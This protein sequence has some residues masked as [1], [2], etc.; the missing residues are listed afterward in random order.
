MGFHYHIVWI[1]RTDWERFGTLQEA[2]SVAKK[3]IRRDET[4]RIEEFENDTC[5]KCRLRRES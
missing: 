2:E 4:Y 1:D 5:I 3:L